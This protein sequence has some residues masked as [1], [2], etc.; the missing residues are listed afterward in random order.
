M[1][2][3]WVRAY[4]G[5]LILAYGSA[6]WCLIKLVKLIL[7]LFTALVSLLIYAIGFCFGK[8]LKGRVVPILARKG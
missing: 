3:K 2:D 1:L 5:V 8:L 6:S 4:V 7:F